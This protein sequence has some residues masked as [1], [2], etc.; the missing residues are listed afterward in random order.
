[1]HHAFERLIIK[2]INR[3]VTTGK[4]LLDI[5]PDIVTQDHTVLVGIGITGWWPSKR[6]DFNQVASRVDM[7]QLETTTDNA[8]ALTK[9]VFDFVRFGISDGVKVF[10]LQT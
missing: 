4:V 8:A 2:R 5:A 7:R 9:D 10:G 3:K 1:M 6:S